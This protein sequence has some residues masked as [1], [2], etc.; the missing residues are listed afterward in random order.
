MQPTAT[1]FMACSRWMLV[2]AL[3]LTAAVAVATPVSTSE[4][5]ATQK[6]L[7]QA[8]LEAVKELQQKDSAFLR[9]RLDA[10]DKSI[11]ALDRR[12]ESQLTQTGQAVDRFG[13]IAGV[14]GTIVTI[15]LFGFGLLGYISVKR[16]TKTE[17]EKAAKHWFEAHSAELER[18]IERL[19]VSADQGCETIGTHVQTVSDTA[20][21]AREVIDRRQK[22]FDYQATD[23]NSRVPKF[24]A[25]ELA[26]LIKR[27][28][29]LREKPEASYSFEDWNTRA[30]AASSSGNKEEACY[31]W[32]LA[33]A[34]PSAGA[35]KVAIALF[36][37]GV[38]LGPLGRLKEAAEALDKVVTLVGHDPAKSLRELVARALVN[39]ALTV[40]K[41]NLNDDAIKV[42]DEVVDRF[43]E[44]P[45]PGL[46][47]QVARALVNKGVSLGNRNLRGDEIKVYDEVVNRYGQDPNPALR[48]QVA[49]ALVNKGVAQGKLDPKDDECKL[50]DAVVDRYGQ[51][52]TPRLREI[53]AS[54]LF[55]KGCAMERLGRS[56]DEIKSFD[57]LVARYRDDP[58]PIARELVARALVNKGDAMGKLERYEDEIK[59]YDDMVACYGKDSAQGLRVVVARALYN[60]SVALKQLGYNE[61]AI[62][63]LH[64]VVDRYGQETDLS[65]REAVAEALNGIGFAKLLQAKEAWSSDPEVARAHLETARENLERAA[66]YTPK[67]SGMIL[68]NH[69]YV[70]WLLGDA[71]GSETLFQ[72]AL[73]AKEHGGKAIY[74]GTL[75]DLTK[76]PIA[77]DAG[78]RALVEHLWK[79]HGEF[80]S[81]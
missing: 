25:E 73:A 45:A 3:S 59:L 78:F 46:R 77:E 34:I 63:V 26:V 1:F 50:F 12:M 37:R 9:E 65:Y 2:L 56:E 19:R 6:E 22:D 58:A 51:D 74:D 55:N 39:K 70:A 66:T 23:A 80:S 71:A 20:E 54:A 14:L 40:A 17:A 30:H 11:A 10:Q 60:K 8:R 32:G 49:S 57:E 24:N 68:G 47:V 27:S 7:L 42:C 4:E 28:A 21:K 13:I 44:D 72:S 69:A 81:L 16:R 67:P 79:E 75:E 36:N 62:Q 64:E 53:V 33:A 52:S 5:M 41:L 48:E 31:L 18:E 61:E 43:G 38:T 35:E 76:H 29:E 15:L